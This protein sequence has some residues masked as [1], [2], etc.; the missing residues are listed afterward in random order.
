MLLKLPFISS[1]LDCKPIKALLLEYKAEV[2][3]E[4]VV[5]EEAEVS[6]IFSYW[7]TIVYNTK[8]IVVDYT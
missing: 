1:D 6:F 4:E 7:K 5:D 8:T 3:E 2:V